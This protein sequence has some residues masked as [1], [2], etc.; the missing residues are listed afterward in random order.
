[1]KDSGHDIFPE[2]TCFPPTTEG[3]PNSGRLLSRTRMKPN[4]V[5]VVG[6]PMRP[7]G[8]QIWLRLAWAQIE[9]RRFS[10]AIHS[11]DGATSEQHIAPDRAIV[12]SVAEWQAREQ[13]SA[14]QDFEIALRGKPEWQNPAWVNALYS[15]LVAQSIQEMKEERERRLKKAKLATNR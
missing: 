15:P 7:G 5:E 13:D 3:N 10:D 8:Q 14:L 2:S 6:K 4:C 9:M 12:R 1:M 11:L